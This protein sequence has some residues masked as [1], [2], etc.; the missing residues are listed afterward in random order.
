MMNA[1]QS[2][3]DLIEFGTKAIDALEQHGIHPILYG[4]LA[5]LAH[6]NDES[7]GVHDIDFLISAA[8]RQRLGELLAGLPSIM[9][10]P[11]SYHSTKVRRGSGRGIRSRRCDH[12]PEGRG[13][14]S[15]A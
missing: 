9:I 3:A 14:R 5:Y 2:L 11:T 1:G 4:S 13:L 8:D 7:Q 15:E 10:E 6:T 12:S